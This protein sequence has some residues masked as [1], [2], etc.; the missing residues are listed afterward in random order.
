MNA[1]TWKE[2]KWK[3]VRGGKPGNLL[4]GI[5]NKTVKVHIFWEG[6]KML[7]NLSRRFVLC[8]ASQIYGGD[9]EKFCGLIKIYE[10]LED[11]NLEGC[12]LRLCITV[13]DGQKIKKFKLLLHHFCKEMQ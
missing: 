4:K 9:F 11:R 3:K 8:S 10:L 7:Q 13:E 1:F 6:H 5:D 12:I 2:E